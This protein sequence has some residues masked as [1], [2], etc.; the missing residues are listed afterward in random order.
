MALARRTAPDVVLVDVR[1]PGMGGTE[2]TRLLAREVPAARVV[3]LTFS[4]ARNDLYEAIR[5]GAVGYGGIARGRPE[6]EVAECLFVPEEAVVDSVRRV[7]EKL[8]HH[9]RGEVA[10]VGA[11]D[12]IVDADR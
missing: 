12:G 7:L 10:V 11:P 4:D 9:A 3:M 2:A 8:Q 5:A 6:S 1:M